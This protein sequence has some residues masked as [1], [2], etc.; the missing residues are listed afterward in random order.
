ML[1]DH[2]WGEN[3]LTF[4]S[5]TPEQ[6]Q[7]VEE[8]WLTP[9]CPTDRPAP[10][11]KELRQAPS[12]TGPDWRERWNRNGSGMRRSTAPSRNVNCR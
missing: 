6:V 5:L 4:A 1:A 10:P 11:P 7:E 3:L 9:A 2:R 12:R 8:Y